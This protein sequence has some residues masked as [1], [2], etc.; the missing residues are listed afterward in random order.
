MDENVVKQKIQKAFSE[1]QAPEEEIRQVI[2]RS[3]AIVMGN[4]A[5]KLL[6]AGMA[7]NLPSLVACTV[8]GQLAKV[9]KLP[10]GATPKQLAQQLEQQPPFIAA[11]R[12][13]NVVQRLNSGELLQQITGQKL[14]EE[15]AASEISTPKIEDPAIG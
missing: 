15:Q 12:G 4:E 11:L 9:S 8:I 2:L 3:R 13:G 14:I 10:D 5:K 1:P 7:E 6:E